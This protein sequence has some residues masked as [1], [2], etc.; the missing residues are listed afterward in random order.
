MTDYAGMHTIILAAL[1]GEDLSFNVEAGARA[2]PGRADD[3][4]YTTD[5]LRDVTRQLHV[6]WNHIH[7]LGF[8]RGARM[9]S[10]LASEL[11]SVW[12]AIAPVS[13]LRFPVPN[14]ASRPIPI[15]SFHG[16]KDMVNPFYG[17]GL[18]YWTESV[19]DVVHQWVIHNQ[20]KKFERQKIDN[21]VELFKHEDCAHGGDVFLTQVNGG[22]HTWPGSKKPTPFGYVSHNVAATV[23]IGNFFHSHPLFKTCWTVT[24]HSRC[25]REVQWARQHGIFDHPEWYPGLSCNTSFEQF[26]E[27][28]H[29]NFLGDCPLPC[30]TST[31]TTALATST[32]AIDTT[33]RSHM[34]VS[35]TLKQHL[36]W[37]GSF[38]NLAEE[39]SSAR[40]MGLRKRPLRNQPALTP[41]SLVAACIVMCSLV[42][43]AVVLQQARRFLPPRNRLQPQVLRDG[44]FLFAEIA[45]SRDGPCTVGSSGL[46]RT[47]AQE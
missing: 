28:L 20:C 18:P 40:S 24:K 2:L 46:S 38:Q 9:C 23:D 12:A 44:F 27:H 30:P 4:A 14:N 37:E 11:S 33:S 45:N 32:I 15:I 7:C 16:T 26:Q 19:P 1:Q 8:S 6:D 21:D 10:R 41:T 17:H 31:T 42:V 29:W 36:G 25:H 39:P 13:G 47:A 22:G 34:T 5:V 35:T 43:A 3:V